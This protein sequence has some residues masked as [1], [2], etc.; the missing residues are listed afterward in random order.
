MRRNARSILL[1]AAALATSAP[2]FA[3]T[4]GDSSSPA[5]WQPSV[6]Q[7]LDACPA[8]V[9]AS[10]PVGHQ[11]NARFQPPTRRATAAAPSR[12]EP[13]AFDP[14]LLRNQRHQAA[15]PRLRRLLLAEIQG[16][17][18][19]FRNTP[20]PAPDRVRIAR[21]LAE[22]YVE[23]EKSARGEQTQ[24][25]AAKNQDEQ[26][27][28]ADLVRRA[29]G[30][31]IAYYTLI[32]NQYPSY[33][34]LDEVLYYLAYEHEQGGDLG[35][36]RKVYYEL[37]KK[38]PT[39]R[40][41][42]SAY[43]AFG[44][45]FFGEAQAD[46]TKFEL[47]KQAYEEVIKYPPPDN[48]MFGYA[49]YKLAYVHWNQGD[50]ALALSHFKRTIEFASQYPAL[51]N[52]RPLADASRKDLIP[53]YALAG[54]PQSA[55][56]FFHPL[57]GDAGSQNAST[58]RMMD[59]LGRAYSDTGHYPEAIALYRD[60]L[61]RD[62]GAGSCGYQARISEAT[63]AMRS[64][65]K[66]AI[67]RVLDEQARTME[68]FSRAAHPA[69]AKLACRGET[70]ALLSET[71][72]AWH[73]EA[74]GSGGVRGTRDPKT[75]K[76]AEQLYERVIGSFASDEFSRFEFPRLMKQD[77]PTLYRVKYHHADLLFS[78]SKW[79]KCGPA[80]DAVFDENP[81]AAE[82]REALYAAMLCYQ[83]V[84]DR[85][86]A[87][88]AEPPSAASLTSY[89]PK[90]LT[91]LQSATI[92]AFDRYLCHFT[93]DKTDREGTD[94]WVEVKYA[95]ARLYFAA[96]HWEQ[97]AVAFRDIALSQPDHDAAIDAAQ[98]YLE[99]ANVLATKTTP[100]RSTCID[101]MAADVPRLAALYCTGARAAGNAEQCTRLAHVECGVK[102]KQAE[103]VIA[104]ADRG[105]P[106]AL[107]K[108]E[109]GANQYLAIWNAFGME[110][111]SR[112]EAPTCDRL[113][114]VVYNACKAFQ[115]GRLVAKAIGCRRILIDPD[116]PFSD[117]ALAHRATYELGGNYQAIAVYDQAADWFER[118]A[119]TRPDR[120]QQDAF[121]YWTEKAGD[122]LSDAV[123]LRLGLGNDQ[124]ALSDAALFRRHFARQSPQRSA[125]IAFAIAAHYVEIGK[126]DEARR[127]LTGNMTALDTHAAYDV[128]VQAYAMLGR[129]Y[130]AL[131]QDANATSAYGKARALWSDPK[132]GAARVYEESKEDSEAV[133]VR[134]LG[135]ALTAVGE[136]L[137]YFAEKQRENSVDKIAFPAYRGGDYRPPRRPL[138]Q[139]SSSEFQQELDAR[140]RETERVQQHID[141]KVRTWV[142]SKRRA[143]EQVND[144]YLE[145]TRLEPAPPRWVIASAAAV[146]TMW[147]E[148]VLDFRRAPI[149]A[150]MAGDDELRGIYYQR[151]DAASE[152]IKLAAKSAYSTCLQ[153]SVAHQ[154]F[155][156]QSR[157]C[158]AWL[159]ENYRGEFHRVDEF[160]GHPD[161]VGSGLNERP[162]PLALGGVPFVA[163]LER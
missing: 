127:Q 43:L 144:A 105:G 31:A 22:A 116:N 78:Q 32:K 97:A 40:Y 156:R 104:Q 23:L 60:L 137:F 21:R 9:A 18:T 83:K 129:A 2:A 24:A 85:D 47:A 67:L 133:R 106:D 89:E 10:R 152:P 146:G 35:N 159:A 16:L 134:R 124:K 121:A 80:F 131:G 87:R 33:K 101:A 51:P 41:V 115:A 3:V 135:K 6:E 92:R 84:F 14:S 64:G 27:R 13:P 71:A 90:P 1:A 45:L 38:A 145:V 111:I 100:Q 50:F 103:S 91:G 58:F 12:P 95:R 157:S 68:A 158:E 110:P 25:Q 155:D 113:D 130:A 102:R 59:R 107:S 86:H 75:L 148:F 39:S 163:L 154:Y 140:K 88:V 53:V 42:P 36:A 7:K 74:V 34:S 112:G 139:M 5:C 8:G 143:I 128:R 162:R 20:R 56:A 54:R 73:L 122:A 29:R 160:R 65:D 117:G 52:A 70:A 77:W 44:E 94:Q 151:L 48:Q 153:R 99:S 114:E 120:K 118:F 30:K 72:M 108:Y 4:P 19:L 132:A 76:A 109:Q 66:D 61:G 136:A 15:A 49:H 142:E 69:E 37:I 149:P 62:H 55:Y 119:S 11:P 98:L 79:E 126:W 96:Q 46:A 28:S 147:S 138:D 93:P 26:R 125:Q 63:M 57:S 161:Q 81:R 141:T 150:W 123:V 17:E 82:A